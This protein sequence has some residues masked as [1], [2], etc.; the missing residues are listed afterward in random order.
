MGAWTLIQELETDTVAEGE[1]GGG[2]EEAADEV[3]EAPPPFSL[4][5]RKGQSERK[6]VCL[7]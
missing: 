3:A 4:R 2:E 1:G 6:R 7:S 5:V